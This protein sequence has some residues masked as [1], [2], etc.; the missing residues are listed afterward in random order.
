MLSQITPASKFIDLEFES[1]WVYCSLMTHHIQL[2]ILHALT[3]TESARYSELKPQNIESNL[4][5]YHLKATI[6]DRLVEKNQDGSYSLSPE[7]RAYADKVSLSSFKIRSQPKI[8]N[9][10]ACSNDDGQWLLYKRK[11]QPY[12]GRSGFPYGKIHLGET[13]KESSERELQEKTTLKADLKY[14]GDVY[15]TVYEHENLI[16]HTLFHVHSGH[17]PTGSLK[18]E[19]PIGYCYWTTIKQDKPDCY[20]PGFLDIYKLL[21]SRKQRFFDEFTYQLES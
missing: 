18:E 5:I 3:L 12:I 20:F 10:L 6:R 2:K 15:V 8:V 4:F 21:T 11:H 7:G 16:T 17:N 13:V 9:L 19:T 14:R 1:N